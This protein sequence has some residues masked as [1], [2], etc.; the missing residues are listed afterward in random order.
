MKKERKIEMDVYKALQRNRTITLVATISAASV[1]IACLVFAFKVYVHN[2]E[3]VLVMN[4]N[5]EAIPV[6]WVKR[7]ETLDAQL[8]H[9]VAMF[10]HNYYQVDRLDLET[11]KQQAFWLINGEDFQKLE[12]YYTA[13]GWF[14]EIK[15]FGIVQRI[16]ILDIGIKGQNEP[17]IFNATI[18]I[19]VIRNDLKEGYILDA[20]G[21]LI[22]VSAV[23]PQNPHGLLIINYKEKPWQLIADNNGL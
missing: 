9:H 10:F 2:L 14:D 1:I 8:K 11:K 12:Q 4:E 18:K 15:R 21:E 19:D 16:E 7:T 23:F 13:K 22:S 20:S 5:G 17:F 6:E 3:R